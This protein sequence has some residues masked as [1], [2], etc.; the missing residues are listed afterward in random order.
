MKDIHYNSAKTR[1]PQGHEYTSEN[2]RIH[3]GRRSCRTC[4][5]VKALA[6]IAAN[7]EL[8]LAQGRARRAR[9]AALRPKKVR[10]VRVRKLSP[11]AAEA[12]RARAIAWAKANPEKM[13]AIRHKRKALKLGNGGSWTAKQWQT[14]KRQYGFRCVGCW[15]T[16]SELTALG[17]KLVPDHIVPVVKGGLNHITNIQPLCHGTGGCN[18]RKGKKYRDFVIS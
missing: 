14:L 5:R 13:R 17:R 2:T 1:C 7:H 15:K 3:G 16:E 18:N 10:I 8:V 11:K 4:E 9:L 6:Y 12:N